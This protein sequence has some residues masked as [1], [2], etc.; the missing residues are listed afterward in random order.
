ME[1]ESSVEFVVGD[2]GGRGL[3]RHGVSGGGLEKALVPVDQMVHFP[4]R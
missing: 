1:L 3:M 4:H 2:W